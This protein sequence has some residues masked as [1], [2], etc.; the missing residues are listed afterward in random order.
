VTPELLYRVYSFE[1]GFEVESLLLADDRGRWWR[2]AD[3]ASLARRVELNA[4]RPSLLYL[5]ARRVDGREPLRTPP[6]QSDYAALW[7]GQAPATGRKE[8]GLARLMRRVRREDA[9]DPDAFERTH[10]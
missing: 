9:F 2:V 7:Q 10:L 1:N 5:R 4:P 8:P 6:Q 3:P